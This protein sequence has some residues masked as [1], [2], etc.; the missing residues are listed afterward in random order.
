MTERPTSQARP[1]TW[2]MTGPAAAD[3][4]LPA[5]VLIPRGPNPCQADEDIVIGL[6]AGY[7]VLEPKGPRAAV[8][9]GR[10]HGRWV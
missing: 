5:R 3:D 9:Q 1:H 7:D 6:R 4:L 8:W 10:D 2:F